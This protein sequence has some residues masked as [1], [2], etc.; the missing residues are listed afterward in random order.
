MG[1]WS[2][3]ILLQKRYKNGQETH[4]KIVKIISWKRNAN[5]NWN[6]YQ[7]TPTTMGKI[8]KS[9]IKTSF[10]KDMENVEPLDIDDENVVWHRFCG[11]V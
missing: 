10:S 2:E 3:Q 6:G 11:I 4:E 9:Q 1:K 8:L 5:L 7:F